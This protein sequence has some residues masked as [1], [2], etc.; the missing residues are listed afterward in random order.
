MLL[1]RLEVVLNVQQH[2]YLE[3]GSVRNETEGDDVLD[4]P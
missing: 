4:T 2:Y 1:Y 3:M